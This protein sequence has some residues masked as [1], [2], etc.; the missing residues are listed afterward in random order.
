MH[1]APVGTDST[2]VGG[3]LRL[4]REVLGLTQAEF[5]DYCDIARNTYNQYEQGR[6]VPQLQLAI[7]LSDTFHLTLDWIYRGDPSGLPFKL[8]DAIRSARPS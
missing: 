5:A 4:T 8:A 6:N 2:S 7:R 3:R 1:R